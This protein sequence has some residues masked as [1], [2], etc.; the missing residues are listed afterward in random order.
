MK[1]YTKDAQL[2][3]FLKKTLSTCLR[4]TKTKKGCYCSRLKR[5]KT[6]NKVEFVIGNN[7]D[8]RA[9]SSNNSALRRELMRQF[10]LGRIIAVSVYRSLRKPGT[11]KFCSWWKRTTGKRDGKGGKCIPV[12][13]VEYAYRAAC[14]CAWQWALFRQCRCA[15]TQL[16]PGLFSF[17]AAGG[18]I[19]AG[20]CK[21]TLNSQ[22]ARSSLVPRFSR[23]LLV[24]AVRK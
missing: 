23:F 1:L 16:I 15:R 22:W 7:L 10:L 17:S 18:D 9:S 24:T 5:I 2:V 11:L 14:R 13:G 21:T 8:R 19:L 6:R 4:G 12:S 20:A 3:S